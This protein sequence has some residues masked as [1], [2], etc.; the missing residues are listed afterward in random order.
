MRMRQASFIL[1]FLLTLP[2]LASP[3]VPMNEAFKALTNLIPFLARESKFI[4]KENNAEILQNMNKLQNAFNQ[5][6]H[7]S[8]LKQDMFAPSLKLLRE[9]IASSKEA[10]EKGNKDYALWSLREI[11]TQ[12]L[13]CHTRLPATHPSSF[14]QGE[15]HIDKSKFDSLYNLA[16][17]QLIVRLYPEA[18]ATFTQDLERKILRKEYA[19]LFLPLQQILL[20]QTKIFKRPQG[21]IKILENYK[22][23]K[24]FTVA[25]YETMNHWMKRLKKWKH[26][27]YLKG[28]NSDKDVEQFIQEIMR[29]LFKEDNVYIGNFDV[30]LLFASGLLSNYLYEHPDSKK[31]PELIYWLGMADK[32]LMRENFFG[33]GERFLKECINRYP[34]HPIAKKCFKE[35]EESMIF[36]YS[37]SRGTD[38]PPDVKKELQELSKKV[39]D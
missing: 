18:K 10:F 13:D 33:S 26:M 19:D 17:A 39:K 2:L 36:N 30:D 37:G 38:I 27:P 22:A 1:C 15:K 21:M 35:Y 11:T 28:L 7:E 12:C 34:D 31:G 24:G 16:L 3:V 6:R 29:P 20:I 5:A 9:N 8:L 32:Y 23:K 4:E 14:Q 25:D